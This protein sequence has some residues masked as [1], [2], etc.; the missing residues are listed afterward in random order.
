MSAV[1]IA[2]LADRYGQ[3][4]H[5]FLRDRLNPQGQSLNPAYVLEVSLSEREEEFA[6]QSDETASRVKLHTT[7]FYR[8]RD[9]ASRDILFRG[10]SLTTNTYNILQSQYA[11]DSSEADARERGARELA[12]DIQTRLAIYFSQQQKG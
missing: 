6:L 1:R 8:L 11:T 9:S 7:A 4:L 10:Q 2:P 5:N 12:D 3:Q